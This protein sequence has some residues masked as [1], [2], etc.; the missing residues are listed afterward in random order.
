MAGET[1]PIM[2][3]PY[4][5]GTYLE[6][7]SVWID[8]NG[9]YDFSADELALQ[10]EGTSDVVISNITIPS[11]AMVGTV[12]MRVS[13][14][15][16]AEATACEIFPYGEVEDYSIV[17]EDTNVFCESP[18]GLNVPQ[19]TSTTALFDWDDM[20]NAVGYNFRGRAYGNTNWSTNYVTVSESPNL[21][22]HSA[23]QTYEWQV[24]T[25]CG[26]GNLSL[27]SAI[28]LFT[29]PQGECAALTNNDLSST[30][31]TTNGLVVTLAWNTVTNA[32]AYRL[33]GRKAGGV[34]K[35][36]PETQQT[37]RTFTSGISYNTSY[38]WSIQVKCNGVWTEYALP[39]ASFT[40]PQAPAKHQTD[41]FDIFD[42]NKSLTARV[43]PNPTNNQ[44]TVSVNTIGWENNINIAIFD[45]T[46]RIVM[47]EKTSSSETT[48]NVSHLNEGYYFVRTENA[49]A[50]GTTKLVIMK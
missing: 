37:S 31:S 1:Y 2:L 29:S 18:T 33:A 8:Y 9:D 22:T 20:S 27:W 41:G 16:N 42:T 38:V 34:T 21:G 43:Y 19:A 45:M 7:W 11:T 14:K 39:P 47:Q 10:S 5:N 3:T 50:V 15:Y 32:E 35:V 17:I 44:V 49:G 28:Q 12:L 40:T 48:L 26:N 6:Y 25:D 30:I 24:Q 4:I 23:G 36:F 46:G 13:M